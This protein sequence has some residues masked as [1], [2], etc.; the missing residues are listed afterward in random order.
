MQGRS[1]APTRDWTTDT[2]NAAGIRLR[3]ALRFTFRA[4]LTSHA[5]TTFN[6]LVP[7]WVETRT[8]LMPCFETSLTVL[9]IGDRECLAT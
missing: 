1:D 9:Q 6:L 4:G 7:R 8:R 2:R 3:L 5:N